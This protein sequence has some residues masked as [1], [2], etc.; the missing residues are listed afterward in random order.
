MGPFFSTQ[1]LD[2]DIHAE[3]KAPASRPLDRSDAAHS[4]PAKGVLGTLEELPAEMTCAG[5]IRALVANPPS[6][7]T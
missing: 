2:E 1:F 4:L 6:T 5:Q 3:A 7:Q